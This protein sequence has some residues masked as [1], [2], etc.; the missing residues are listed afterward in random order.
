MIIVRSPLRITL[1]GGGSDLLPYANEYGGFCVSAAINKYVYVV[2]NRLFHE[3]ILLKYS[4]LEKVRNISD[5]KHATIREALKLLNFK[6]PQIEITTFSDIPTVGSG[7]GGSG[8]F[9][10]ALLRA[11]YSHRNISKTSE[12]IAELACDININKL[13]Y[14]QGK[15][16][17]YI[18]ALGGIM[19][20][21][22][23]ANTGNVFHHPLNIAFDTLVEL[24]ENLMLFYTGISHSTNNI[25]K[26]QSE[27]IASNDSD[28][29]SNLHEVKS[30]GNR[31]AKA[32]EDGD[33]IKFS[34]LLNE[35][36]ENKRKRNCGE[37]EFIEKVYY[38][39]FKHGV[40][41][42]KLVGSGAGGFLLTYAEDKN[43]V[44]K[45]MSEN[46]LQELK[47]NFDYA[48]V[49]QIN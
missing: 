22:F 23:E 35:Q 4:E 45:Y 17:E 37:P 30:I 7:L 9:S 21:S 36:W 2:V 10:V 18:S 20:L 42:M 13:G 1:G 44:R 14:A 33:L 49:K 26:G 28:I 15:Q 5:I 11:L 24:K 16:D 32:L 31:S 38:G 27:K 47:F 25:L 6:T 3:E 43:R 41:G 48:G 19:G 39:S 34:I 12:E 46:G 8:A 40:L 29:I